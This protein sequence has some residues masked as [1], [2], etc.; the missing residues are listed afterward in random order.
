MTNNLRN[1]KARAAILVALA[2]TA[3]DMA[4]RL[5]PSKNHQGKRRSRTRSG[6][7]IMGRNQ[8]QDRMRR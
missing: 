8:P 7:R 6:L 4:P 1:L 2:M 3:A 5:L